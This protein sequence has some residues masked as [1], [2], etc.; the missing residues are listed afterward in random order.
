MLEHLKQI[1]VSIFFSQGGPLP[2]SLWNIDLFVLQNWIKASSFI[3]SKNT[4]DIK[5]RK[6]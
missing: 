2:G 3:Y 6:V 5:L 1:W 4:Q